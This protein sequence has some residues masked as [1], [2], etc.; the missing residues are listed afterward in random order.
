MIGVIIGVSFINILDFIWKLLFGI[1]FE[2]SIGI[3][4]FILNEVFMLCERL[5]LFFFGL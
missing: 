5:N 1:I 2:I 4:F 3:S